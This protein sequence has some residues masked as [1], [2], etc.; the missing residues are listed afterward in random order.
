MTRKV[1]AIS[2]RFDHIGAP[3]NESR[4]AL[5]IRLAEFVIAADALPVPVP[6][7]VGS[8]LLGEWLDAVQPDAILLSGGGDIGRDQARDTVEEGLLAYAEARHLPVLGICRGMQMMAHSAGASLIEVAG[9]VATRHRITGDISREVNS[10]HGLALDA[11]PEDYTAVA[12]SEDGVVEAMVHRSRRWEG[13]MWHPEREP[14]PHRDDVARFKE[15]M[16]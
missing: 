1:V 9:H 3:H 13:W 11:V 2:Q 6:S 4:D 16:A 10:Y 14:T 15:L 5:D 12:A 8:T 7:A